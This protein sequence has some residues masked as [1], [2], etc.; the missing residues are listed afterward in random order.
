[1]Y[2]IKVQ[3][4]IPKDNVGPFKDKLSENGLAQEGNY[5]YCFFESK[6]EGNSNQLVKLIQQ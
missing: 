2:T 5:E 6:E 1:M 3:T 4:Y